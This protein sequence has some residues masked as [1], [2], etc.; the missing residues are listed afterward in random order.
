MFHSLRGLGICCSKSIVCGPELI[1]GSTKSLN[2]NH[3]SLE[4]TFSQRLSVRFECTKERA[5]AL[6]GWRQDGVLSFGSFKLRSANI[7]GRVRLTLSSRFTRQTFTL[8][9]V[10]IRACRSLVS[11]SRSLAALASARA[12]PLSFQNGPSGSF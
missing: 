11:A 7:G 2:T 1:S 6:R 4:L 5:T 3:N 12:L 10:L 9:S 8:V